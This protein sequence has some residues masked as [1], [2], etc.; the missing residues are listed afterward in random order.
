[1]AKRAKKKAK[2][3][4][5]KMKKKVGKTYRSAA[6]GKFV[7]KDSARRRPHTTVAESKK[8]HK[9]KR[10]SFRSADSGRYVQK[11]SARRRPHTTIT[12]EPQ[13]KSAAQLDREIAEALTK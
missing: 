11:D 9:S 2:T 3:A 5:A 7:Q 6:S 1:M 8:K 10:R 4:K 12:S 13:V